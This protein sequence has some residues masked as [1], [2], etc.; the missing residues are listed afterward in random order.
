MS[1]TE[2]NLKNKLKE[3][4]GYNQFRGNQELIIN[5]II[6][7][8]NTFVIMPTGAGKS[9]CYQ[10]PALSLP[11]TA[12][13]ISPLIALMKNQVDQLNAFG[14]NAQFLNSTLSKSEINKVKKETLAGEVK[15][16]YV[17]P[18][19]LTKEETIEFLRS[20]NISFVAIDEA[21]CISEWGHDFRP[22][23][24]RIRGIIDQIGNLPII[25]LTAT[26]TP[27]VQLDIQRNLQMDEASVFK[28]SFNRTNL[29]YEVRPKHKTKKQLIQYVK[30]NKGKSGV[31]YCLSRKKVE[32]IA[33]LLRVNDV[34]A[35]PYHAGLDSH[36]R[37][38]NQDAFLNEDCDVIVATIAFGM[39]I[40]KPDVR[41]VIHYDTPKSI[42]GYYQETGRAGRDG[43][44]GNCLMF[45]SYDDIV[46]LEKFNKDKPVTE[47]DNSKL[48]LQEMASYADSA[49]CRR[50]QLL[51]YFG[52]AYEK[53]CGFC[54]NCLHPKERFQ[55]Q[56]EV[57]NALKAVEQ[58]GERFTI[59]H[60]TAVLTGLR[61]QHVSSYEHDTLE[62]FGIGKEQDVQFWSSVLRQVLLSEYLEKD[63][64]NFGVV[65]LTDKGRNFIVNPQPIELTKDHNFEQEVKEDEENEQ[66]Q[67]AAGH[68]EVLFDL[69][70]NL[71][72]K[73]AKEKNL[74][75]YVLFQDPSLKE[76]ATV[77]PTTK[78][79]L[80]HIAGVGMGKV[81]KFGKPFL[82]MI[83]KYVDENDIVTAADVVVKTTVNKSKIK[84]Y[85]IQQIDKKVDLEEIASSKG[86]TMQE[87][88]EE[89]EHICYSGTKLNLNYYINNVLDDERQEEIYDYF[90]QASTD[91]IAVALKELGTD[92]YTEEDLRL[93]RIK[94]LSE[95]AN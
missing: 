81:Q 21:H 70:K 37:M 50:K 66:S 36:I 92:D 87:L 43:L 86:L 83:T 53:D 14:V 3:V 34:K 44:E 26:A 68:D 46:K 5:N 78:E 48:L 56:N 63:I 61:N 65:K 51:H 62:V 12:I 74:P 41:F 88:I 38:A 67:A 58:T 47:R 90:M 20:S 69:L 18:E 32:E 15:L 31:V 13:V 71:R 80:A 10:L 25:A 6:N 24:R 33:E 91:N 30:K 95:Y 16:L 27:K 82:D 55:A 45:Y 23:Y 29:Y 9:L 89:V 28:S 59:E 79:D 93:M 17:A 1:L 94:F 2:V 73:L 4:F 35:L 52:E 22:E 60:I 19:S 42:E 8:K 76:M 75:P 39:G 77:Y 40:D 64:E 54:D 11:G 57:V 84:I 72:K 49:V 85:I 7:G